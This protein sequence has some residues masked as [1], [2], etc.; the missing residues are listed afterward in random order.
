ML[1]LHQKSLN[2]I[3]WQGAHTCSC[4]KLQQLPAGEVDRLAAR[5]PERKPALDATFD[6]SWSKHMIIALTFLRL[7]VTIAARGK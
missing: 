6:F 1:W 2:P 4:S 5:C 7:T 3:L